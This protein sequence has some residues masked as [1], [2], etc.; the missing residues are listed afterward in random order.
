MTRRD[1]VKHL[2]DVYEA[3][4]S[5]YGNSAH[6]T[7]V[8][9]GEVALV[10]RIS[11]K[12]SR[13]NTLLTSGEQNVKDESVLDT[14][15]DAITYLCMLCADMDCDIPDLPD[16][17]RLEMDENVETTILYLQT[18]EEKKLELPVPAED[19]GQYRELLIAIWKA[20]ADPEIRLEEYMNL[21]EQLLEEYIWRVS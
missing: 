8:E 18:L 11:D 1:V 9:F 20:I 17:E 5:D 4:N 21:A 2:I 15:G 16:A 7:Y 3:K 12:L 6:R 19:V 10:I 13:L 14:I